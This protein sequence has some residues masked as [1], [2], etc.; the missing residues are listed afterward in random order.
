MIKPTGQIIIGILAKNNNHL[1]V[2]CQVYT[3][4]LIVFNFET[5]LKQMGTCNKNPNCI[6]QSSA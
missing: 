3:R 5:F 6:Y 4:I 2:T 1:S